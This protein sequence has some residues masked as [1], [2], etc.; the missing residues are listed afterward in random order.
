MIQTSL[1]HVWGTAI[2]YF[3]RASM[4]GGICLTL[5]ILAPSRSNDSLPDFNTI[6]NFLENPEEEYE[7]G[8]IRPHRQTTFNTSSTTTGVNVI[9]LFLALLFRQNELGFIPL[10]TLF[11]I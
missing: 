3:T 10:A 1:K 7:F 4:T 2:T 6:E 5:L 8:N 11:L 9:P